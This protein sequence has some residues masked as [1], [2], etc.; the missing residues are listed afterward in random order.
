[1]SWYDY[2]FCSWLIYFFVAFDCS[3]EFFMM[4]YTVVF[5]LVFLIRQ[6][7]TGFAA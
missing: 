6:F 7:L 2:L 4:S 3:E 1:M 5:V